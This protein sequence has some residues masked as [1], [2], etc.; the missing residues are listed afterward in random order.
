MK[1]A[2]LR[3]AFLD[4]YESKGHRIVSSSSLVPHNDPTLL[5][6]NAGMNQFKDPLWVNRI[7]ATQEQRPRNVA[8]VREESITILKTSVTPQDTIRFSK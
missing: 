5:F 1:T 3:H 2:D 6:T 7:P 4:F 8:C